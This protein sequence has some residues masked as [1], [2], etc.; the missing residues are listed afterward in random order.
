MEFFKSNLPQI[1]PSLLMFSI[2]ILEAFIL[3]KVILLFTVNAYLDFSTFS[4][5]FTLLFPFGLKILAEANP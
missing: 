2:S 4:T 1:S 5:S 3:F